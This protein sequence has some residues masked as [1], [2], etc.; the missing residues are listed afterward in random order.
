MQERLDCALIPENVSSVA[1]AIREA[2]GRAFLVGGP[3]R[4]L[5]L[6]L[7]PQDWDVATDLSPQE[8]LRVFPGASTVGIEFGRVEVSGVD[9]VSLRGETGYLDGRHPSS[10]TFGVPI[11][12]DLRR[13]DFTVNAMAAEFDDMEIIDPF[14]GREDVSRRI[15]RAVGDA[16][17]RLAEDPL[18]ILRAVRLKTV[19]GFNLDPSVSA[20]LLV[21]AGTLRSVSGERVF[22]ELSRILLSGAVYQGIRD[23][24]AYGA[25]EVI[26]PEVFPG[27]SRAP[28]H[29]G[30]SERLPGGPPVCSTPGCG[31]VDSLARA[32]SYSSPDLSTRLALLFMG[33]A[34]PAQGGEAV[35]ARAQ[36]GLGRL[37]A[38]SDVRQAVFWLI[39]NAGPAGFVEE[40]LRGGER[41]VAYLARRLSAEAGRGQVVSLID[42]WQAM[43][44]AAGNEGFPAAASALVAGLWMTRGEDSD[45]AA[46]GSTAPVPLA[47]SGEDVM[48]VLGQKAGPIV[49][50]ALDHLK[51]AVLRHPGLNR[52]D[53]L[54]SALRVWWRRR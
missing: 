25:G 18:R 12:E 50:E 26:L 41:N 48:K 4:D 47:L 49:G 27:G 11:E 51:D 13:R 44:R 24:S 37:A 43:W 17:R 35:L 22:A 5:L 7:P 40:S 20:L 23:L 29:G 14:G 52:R 32:L 39:R 45:A 1:S 6:G 8:V 42:A 31:D 33:G 53:L 10:V 21:L 54:E 3:V 2:S 46:R 30:T 38:P 19:L 34:T 36:S 16:R 15:L 9:V 28:A